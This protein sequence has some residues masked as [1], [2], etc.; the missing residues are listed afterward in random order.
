[1]IKFKNVL[2]HRVTKRLAV[3]VPIIIV[4]LG[5]L[6]TFGMKEMPVLSFLSVIVIYIFVD[7]LLSTKD[8]RKA[9]LD[10]ALLSGDFK[11]W[12]AYILIFIGFLSSRSEPSEPAVKL[13]FS[14]VQMFGIVVLFIVPVIIFTIN[15][16]ASNTLSFIDLLITR[17]LRSL[18]FYSLALWL[19]GYGGDQLYKWVLA[20]PNDAVIGAVAFVIVWI[21][22]NLSG[23]LSL[24][25]KVIAKTTG[26]ASLTLSVRVPKTTERDNRY[27]AAH[28]AGHALVYAAL[29]NLHLPVDVK[30]I[31]ND[32]SDGHGVLGCITNV[33][34][35][36]RLDEKSFAEWYMLVFLAGKLGETVIY[37]ESTLG[38]SNDHLG[39]LGVARNYLAN[40]YRG[41]YYANPRSKFEQERN[42][43]KLEALQAEQLEMLRAFFDINIEVFKQLADTL[44][45]KRIMNR[46]ELIP[47][48]S[49]VK[50]PD[51]F[52]LPFGQYEKGA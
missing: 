42:E 3:T 37:D 13:I 11:L 19:I 32:Y 40:H 30:L 8:E 44:L 10:A 43:I 46:D 15:M 12:C 1:M 38:S 25:S 50:L 5:L 24:E 6:S 48:L 41:M 36:N 45:E 35:N 20:N 28:E 16:V 34:S 17:F 9:F 7:W 49:R 29:G 23:G 21:I 27:I 4:V 2:T 31:V 47:F 39:W 33:G 52:P 14:L 22:F 26:L 18:V 51:G